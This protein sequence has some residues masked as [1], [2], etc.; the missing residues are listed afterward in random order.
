LTI[1]GSACLHNLDTILPAWLD[2]N[3]SMERLI[4]TTSVTIYRQI[5]A[6]APHLTDS[7]FSRVRIAL[8]TFR[9]VFVYTSSSSNN[10]FRRSSRLS[11][12]KTSRARIGGTA[13][14]DL[15]FF[16]SCVSDFL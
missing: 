2:F 16:A 3:S 1:V 9:A 10:L 13:L 14:V 4:Y 8:D 6:H 7:I 15:R 11:F 12:S 5:K